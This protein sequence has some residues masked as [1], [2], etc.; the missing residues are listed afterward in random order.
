MDHISIGICTYKRSEMLERLLKKLDLQYTGHSFTYSVNIIDND[1]EKSAQKSVNKSSGVNYKI[2]Y[3]NVMEKN[4]AKARNKVL[5]TAEGKYLALID[6]DEYPND[7]WLFNHY[8]TCTKYGADGT[9]GP[10]IAEFPEMCPRWIIESNVCKRK[11]FN[12]GTI[13]KPQNARTGNCLLLH[14]KILNNKCLFDIEFG[15]SGGEDVD[16]FHKLIKVN[17]FKIVWCNE[18]VVYEPVTENRLSRKFYIQRAIKRGKNSQRFLEKNSSV[19]YQVY[20]IIKSLLTMVI[21]LILL[22]VLLFFN[23]KIKMAGIE[24]FFHH[25]GRIIAVVK[26]VTLVIRRS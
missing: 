8:F 12:T 16:F 22:P 14:E 2:S 13:I 24:S 5:E 10:V 4:I 9:L 3:Y 6:D 21:T 15:L 11:T 25:L 26:K 18:A 19:L 20:I 23:E 17:N 7:F 1:Y